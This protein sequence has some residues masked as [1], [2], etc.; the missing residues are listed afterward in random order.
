[1]LLTLKNVEVKEE[2]IANVQIKTNICQNQMCIKAN[3]K[4]LDEFAEAKCSHLIN[5]MLH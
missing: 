4:Q 2:I 3:T 5:E 1:M